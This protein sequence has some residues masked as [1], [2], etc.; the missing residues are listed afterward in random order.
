MADNVVQ[1]AANPATSVLVNETGQTIAVPGTVT[2]QIVQTVDS[3]TS[4]T[5]ANTGPQG[6]SGVSVF[7]TIH[8]YAIGGTL[9]TIDAIPPMFFQKLSSQTSTLRKVVHRIAT[10]T[11]ATITLKQ[12]GADV[13]GYTGINVTS[14]KATTTQD[15]V[16]ADGD[17]L[18]LVVTAVSG[19]PTNLTFTLVVEHDVS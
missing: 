1:I 15:V 17:E 7:Q 19:A 14:S 4:V 11:S 9:N 5:L 8:T 16:L 3:G 2:T 6:P 12:N 18:A 10:G 13:T